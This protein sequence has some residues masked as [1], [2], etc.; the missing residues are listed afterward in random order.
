MFLVK[1]YAFLFLGLIQT[2]QMLGNLQDFETCLKFCIA[3]IK[4]SVLL[5]YKKIKIKFVHFFIQKEKSL[6]FF[7]FLY[8]LLNNILLKRK[9]HSKQI[10]L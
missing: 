3:I 8:Y 9:I 7:F 5:Y 10:Y 4:I 2:S 6:T 1:K